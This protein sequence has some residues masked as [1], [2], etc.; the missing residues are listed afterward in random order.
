MTRNLGARSVE[1]GLARAGGGTGHLGA[2]DKPDIRGEEP[3]S[4]AGANPPSASDRLDEPTSS[5][6]WYSMAGCA[7]TDELLEW[8]PDVFA[9]TSI[10]PVGQVL[11]ETY[12]HT[13]TN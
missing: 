8:P 6:V 10:R 3:V 4:A 1:G 9:L 11:V 13:K 7:I 12:V 2:Y 5:H